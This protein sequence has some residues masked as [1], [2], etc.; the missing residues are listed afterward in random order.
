MKAKRHYLIFGLAVTMGAV[1]T[2]WPA[3]EAVAGPGKIARDAC[4]GPEACEDPLTPGVI[5][6]TGHIQSGA[7]SGEKSCS[8][9][10]RIIKGQA[11][12]GE[13]SCTDN[14]AIIGKKSCSGFLSC[15]MNMGKIGNYSC[16][17]MTPD[18]EQQRHYQ[19][20][21]V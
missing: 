9:N 21:V 18:G 4:L 5:D 14:S 2:M 10:G 6:N 15:V 19:E 13:F 20:Q 7:C 17:K 11:C 1:L 16:R 3:Q 12:S 8:S